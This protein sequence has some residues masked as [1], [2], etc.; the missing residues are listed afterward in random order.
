MPLTVLVGGQLGSEGKGKIAAYLAKEYHMAIRTGGPNAGHTVEHEG[1]RYKVQSVPCGFIN[2]H[3]LL[4][5][6]AGGL[7][8]MDLL[9]K[10]IDM[11]GAEGRLIIDPHAAIIEPAHVLQERQALEAV[12]STGEGVGAAMAHRVTRHPRL[13]L[14]KDVPELEA[15]IRPVWQL[16]N[17]ML[18]EGAHI[19]LEGTQGFG[20]SLY[21]GDY[22]YVTSRDTTAGTLVA[23]AGLSPRM[24]SDVVMVIRSYPIRA[25]R[26]PLFEEIDWRTVTLESGSAAPITELTSITRRVRRV[27]RLDLQQLKKAVAINR[28]SQVAL[29]FMDYVDIHAAGVSAYDQLG[30]RCHDF[31]AML[32]SELNVPVTLIGTGDA[33]RDIID[34]R[35]ALLCRQGQGELQ[36]GALAD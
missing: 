35:S 10:E 27:G 14:A 22:P 30:Q 29:T 15:Y 20:L 26:G 4:A 13:R 6:G 5:I 34:R 19:F 12:L 7:I 31:V 28:P 2:P 23:D 32:E 9:V 17:K 1:Q 3:C 21:H 18:D 36:S 25:S 33:A 24:V 8:N 11:T 16:A